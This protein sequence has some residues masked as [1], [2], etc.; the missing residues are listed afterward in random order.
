MTTYVL[1]KPTDHMPLIRICFEEILLSE[2]LL[3]SNSG[4]YLV[5]SRHVDSSPSLAIF[6]ERAETI[7]LRDLMLETLLYNNQQEDYIPFRERGK[8]LVL[9]LSRGS[10][11]YKL[12]TLS[13]RDV[14]LN[15]LSEVL[16]DFL[17]VIEIVGD[18]DLG[19]PVCLENRNLLSA[20]FYKQ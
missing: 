3:K 7:T 10:D 20:E 17:L 18:S 13:T 16:S 2:L 1:K 8:R 5:H 4:L 11:I 6:R 12:A 19:I 9:T 14:F 15:M